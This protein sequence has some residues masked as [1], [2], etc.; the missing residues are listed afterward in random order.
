MAENLTQVRAGSGPLVS[1]GT[2]LVA[3]GGVAVP[4]RHRRGRH[5]HG[6][7]AVVLLR[8]TEGGRESRADR[9]YCNAQKQGPMAAGPLSLLSDLV[10]LAHPEY[11]HNLRTCAQ[12]RSTQP[13]EQRYRPSS[14][15][16]EK[17]RRDDNARIYPQRRLRV[18]AVGSRRPVA[19]FP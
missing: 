16:W 13:T 3:G 17:A 10:C 4:W 9:G 19:G 18:P 1:H 12:L 15:V 7:T 8:W 2:Y 5:G 6:R 11:F 14:M